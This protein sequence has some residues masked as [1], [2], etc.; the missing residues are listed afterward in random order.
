MDEV[1][2]SGAKSYPDNERSV[3]QPHVLPVGDLNC[4]LKRIKT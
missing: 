4:S 3:F 2:T 1:R